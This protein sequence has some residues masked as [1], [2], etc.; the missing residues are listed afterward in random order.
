M[1]EQPENGNRQVHGGGE[2]DEVGAASD[3][4]DLRVEAAP[5]SS[6]L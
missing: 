2:S 5:E 4:G 6:R 1:V 3:H